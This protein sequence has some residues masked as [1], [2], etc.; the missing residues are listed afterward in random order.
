[1]THRSLALSA[2][3]LPALLLGCGPHRG[4]GG[5]SS[6]AMSRAVQ[7]RLD[8]LLEGQ[9]ITHENL[10]RLLKLGQS[11]GTGEITLFFEPGTAR[12]SGNE[13]VRLVR[14]L[15]R[16]QMES[17]GRELRFVCVGSAAANGPIGWNDK[18]SQRR[19]MAAR[20]TIDHVLV[21]A[22][23]E[24]LDLYGTGA[25]QSPPGVGWQIDRRYRSVRVIAVYDEAQLP[26]LPPR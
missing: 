21:N 18:L 6:A 24:F 15:D 2:M 12:L 7:E 11:Q 20:S 1:M 22:P 4:G 17:H 23:H 26:E 13:E 19:A 3:L 9:G 25:N 8:V 5:G 14:F 16:L 10:E